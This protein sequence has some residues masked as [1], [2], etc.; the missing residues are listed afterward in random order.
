MRRRCHRDLR[1]GA[2]DICNRLKDAGH[3]LFSESLVV[4]GLFGCF[5]ISPVVIQDERQHVNTAFCVCMIANHLLILLRFF[6]RNC[7]QLMPEITE[8]FLEDFLLLRG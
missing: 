5:W 8:E 4:R 2:E 6:K 1:R 7:E 3:A